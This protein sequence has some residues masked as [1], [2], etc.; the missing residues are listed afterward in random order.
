M[1]YPIYIRTIYNGYYEPPTEVYECRECGIHTDE[2][3]EEGY[4]PDCEP[5]PE[6]EPEE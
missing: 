4:C 2:I 6:E 5:E 1:Q 3:S